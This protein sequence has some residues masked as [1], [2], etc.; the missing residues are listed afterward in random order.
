MRR[1]A[2]T[3]PW[4]PRR[5]PAQNCPEGFSHLPDR[6]NGYGVA[7]SQPSSLPRRKSLL[8]SEKGDFLWLLQAVT[9]GEQVGKTGLGQHVSDLR[10]VDLLEQ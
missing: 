3:E 5:S 1:A 8:T 4:S 9:L 2:T 7:L 10:V 6:T